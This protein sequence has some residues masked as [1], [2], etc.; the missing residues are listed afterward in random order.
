MD[1]N[2]DP[3]CYMAKDLDMALNVYAEMSL[4]PQVAMQATQIKLIFSTLLSPDLH[5]FIVF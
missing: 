4:C 3:C 2:T 1:I 5:L